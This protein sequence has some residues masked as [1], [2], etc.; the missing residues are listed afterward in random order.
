[1][2]PWVRLN[3]NPSEERVYFYAKDRDPNNWVASLVAGKDHKSHQKLRDYIKEIPDGQK[4]KW[5]NFD[6]DLC[7]IAIQNQTLLRQ[8]GVQKLN[9]NFRNQT[10]TASSNEYFIE[11]SD[12]KYESGC[13]HC[14]GPVDSDWDLKHRK[15][16]WLICGHCGACGCG[17]RGK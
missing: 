1:M 3:H 10:G 6:A 11:L 15:C 4:A 12:N 13:W 16:G 5:G 8:K 14:K 9:E 7:A 2:T 17:Y